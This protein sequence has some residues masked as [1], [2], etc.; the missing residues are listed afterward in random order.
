MRAD[1]ARNREKVLVAARELF[2]EQ[3]FDVPLDEIAAKAGV[4]PGTVYRH[5]PTKQALFQAVTEARVS[6]M[7][8][9][10]EPSADAGADLFAFLGKMADEATAKRDMSDAIAVPSEL[11]DSLHATLGGL[12]A[13][14]Q[15]AGAVRG[16]ITTRDL[17][18]L[19]K[20]MLQSMHEGANPAV[21][22]QIVLSGLQSSRK[23]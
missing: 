10:A 4:G 11:R 2:A 23:P 21:L 20:G 5:F 19:M 12:L 8:A 17:V 9:S 7:I 16:D 22:L 18:A 14:A 6:A 15:E 13:R 1:A 3:G